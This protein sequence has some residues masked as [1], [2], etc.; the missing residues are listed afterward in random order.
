MPGFF[1]FIPFHA[2]PWQ[3]S[4]SEVDP[5]VKEDSESLTDLSSEVNAMRHF[6]YVLTPTRI[7]N[8]KPRD[9]PYKLT[10]GGGLFVL[11]R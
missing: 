4:L 5:K 3:T 2:I 11:V 9:K 10:D 7:N 6:N 1:H 8:A